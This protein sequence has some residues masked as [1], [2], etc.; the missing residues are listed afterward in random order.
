MIKDYAPFV[1]GAFLSYL[2]DRHYQKKPT[3]KPFCTEINVI[4]TSPSFQL[5]LLLFSTSLI[6]TLYNP[7]NQ[8]NIAIVILLFLFMMGSVSLRVIQSVVTR[9]YTCIPWCRRSREADY[10]E[11]KDD[12]E[13][14]DTSDETV[15]IEMKKH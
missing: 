9:F 10:T 2:V 5:P 15:E 7:L 6:P 3:R 4:F 1:F 12:Y 14:K 13:R 8:R 11:Q